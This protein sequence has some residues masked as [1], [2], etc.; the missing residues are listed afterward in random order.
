MNES[1]FFRLQSSSAASSL[2]IGQSSTLEAGGGG[3]GGGSISQLS[4][5]PM[6]GEGVKV[7]A[8]KEIESNGNPSKPYTGKVGYLDKAAAKIQVR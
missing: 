5:Q 1:L 3:D 8:S 4:Q 6:N 7:K 2:D